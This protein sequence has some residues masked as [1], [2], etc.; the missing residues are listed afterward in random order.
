VC[1]SD[2]Y[3][4]WCYI[5]PDFLSS[6]VYFAV[7]WSWWRV[8]AAVEF[9]RIQVLLCDLSFRGSLSLVT[10]YIEMGLVYSD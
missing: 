9:L 10:Q 4:L 3:F 2:G 8:S 7:S 1:W 5:C 6:G